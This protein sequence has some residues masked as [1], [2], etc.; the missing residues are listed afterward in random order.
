MILVRHGQ[1]VANAERRFTRGA[2]EPLSRAG[3]EEALRTARRL[4]ERFDPVALYSS[5]FVRALETA[6]L[7]GGVLGLEPVVVEAL[8]EQDFGELRGHPYSRFGGELG[9][10]VGDPWRLRPP[11]G[12][13]LEEVARRAGPALDALAARHAGEEIVVVSHGGVMAALRAWVVQQEEARFGEPPVVS[14]NAGG[15]LIEW[16]ASRYLGPFALEL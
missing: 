8:R 12:E 5:P 13:T 10:A 4:L 7:V 2:H 1:S 3:R 11:G 15:Y 16:R 14:A 9:G 6:R